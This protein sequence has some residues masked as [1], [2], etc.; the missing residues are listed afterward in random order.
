M[1]D[2]QRRW[3]QFYTAPEIVDLILGFCL[4]QPTDWLLDPS[5]GEGA[6]LLRAARY[7]RW[8]SSSAASAGRQTLWGIEIDRDAALAARSALAK[9]GHRAHLFAQ[10]FFSLRPGQA[11]TNIDG[12]VVE[13]PPAFDCVVGNPPYTRSEWLSRVSQ[14]PGYRDRLFAEVTTDLDESA[15]L[16]KR[17]GLHVYFF[18]HASN[19]L[20]PGGRFGFVASN[21]WLD[22]DYGRGLKQF[23][24]DRFRILTI[25]ESAVE[26]WFE[27]ASVNTCLVILERCDDPGERASNQV[28]LARLRR[29]LGDLIAGP[30]DAPRR[31]VEVENLVMRLLPG[32]SRASAD[33]AVRV[34]RQ[35][36]LQAAEKWGPLLRAPEVFFVARG[37]PHTKPLGR[38][39]DIRRGQTT[40]ANSFFYLSQRE[41][42]SRGVEERFL[43]P[44]LKS[45]KEIERLTVHSD[46]LEGRVL[47]VGPDPDNLRQTGALAYIR[48]AE[49]EGI[50]RRSTCARRSP[51]YT[52]PRQASVPAYLAWPKGVWNRHFVLLVNGP[53]IADQ[54]FYVLTAP[55][56]RIRALAALLNS[57][58]A[59]LQ[60]ELVGR[61]NFGEGVLWLAGYEVA[62]LQIPDFSDL[63]PS[64]T[65]RLA[66]AFDNLAAMPL[67]PLGMAVQ[68]PV[69]Q[70]LDHLVFDLLGLSLSERSDL[71]EAAVR[72]VEERVGRAVAG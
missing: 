71:V 52:L 12:E 21:S 35:A 30:Q 42:R 53:I 11:A 32:A 66:E 26:Q 38:L 24:L 49:R 67:C 64:S 40:G 17:A 44:L 59:A 22:V 8:L 23:L 60:A 61:S 29:P 55:P 14:D 34:V 7:R 20:R 69:Q 31:A 50:H 47:M 10:D 39:V 6:F 4:R 16:S 18:L 54:Q 13:L 19:F 68:R 3:G 51:W 37:A 33:L 41:A 25:I 48:L 1:S 56:D 62:Q 9:A 28:R 5:C 63:S 27:S 57:T 65:R 2:K 58:W 72:L 46:D 45:P 36:D 43:S 15:A 70:Q